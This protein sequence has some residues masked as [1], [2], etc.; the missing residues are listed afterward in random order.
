MG[1]DEDFG[2]TLAQKVQFMHK[3][4]PHS[5]VTMT[6]GNSTE[7][8]TKNLLHRTLAGCALE[9]DTMDV[10]RAYGIHRDWVTHLN[11]TLRRQFGVS[12]GV[13][14]NKQMP[15]CYLLG[16]AYHY[17]GVLS[18]TKQKTYS[19]KNLVDFHIIA[20]GFGRCKTA[21]A[22]ESRIDRA[23]LLQVFDT[24]IYDI[25]ETGH[26]IARRLNIVDAARGE[27]FIS[28][29]TLKAAVVRGRNI[30]NRRYRAVAKVDPAELKQISESYGDEDVATLLSDVSRKGVHIGADPVLVQRLRKL[31]PQDE[32]GRYRKDETDRIV[33]EVLRLD[34]THRF[35][36]LH[37]LTSRL[38]QKRGRGAFT[39]PVRLVMAP[40]MDRGDIVNY[41]EKH[42]GQARQPILF[43]KRK[44]YDQFMAIFENPLD[45]DQG[46]ENYYTG[47]QVVG[48]FHD[49]VDEGIHPNNI[50]GWFD[51][52]K[53][54]IGLFEKKPV[55]D[56]IRKLAGNYD[57]FP[58]MTD[59][60]E[61]AK[62][63]DKVWEEYVNDCV[64]S[65]LL[66]R[67]N[68]TNPRYFL[69]KRGEAE[70]RQ[71]R[72]ERARL[73]ETEQRN[74]EHVAK[75]R[76]TLVSAEQ[77]A[78]LV[79]MPVGEFRAAADK[80]GIKYRKR[81]EAR[82]YPAQSLV[83]HWPDKFTRTQSP[84]LIVTNQGIR[85]G[86]DTFM[87]AYE[88]IRD[89]EGK[90][91]GWEGLPAIILGADLSHA[92]Q[93]CYGF[94]D[95]EVDSAL[96]NGWIQP[97]IGLDKK[98][99]Y[100]RSIPP[101][102]SV[103]QSGYRVADV[104][105]RLL[106]VMS[107]IPKH[108]IPQKVLLG[109]HLAR[110]T[111]ELRR[112][113]IEKYDADDIYNPGNIMFD[114]ERHSFR[115]MWPYMETRL[116]RKLGLRMSNIGAPAFPF[117]AD[118]YWR[119][120]VPVIDIA[121]LDVLRNELFEIAGAI[122]AQFGEKKEAAPVE[123]VPSPRSVRRAQRRIDL[124]EKES[125][126]VWWEEFIDRDDS[127]PLPSIGIGY[128][129]HIG[130]VADLGPGE[131]PKYPRA[132]AIG[133]PRAEGKSRSYDTR[134]GVILTMYKDMTTN[135]G[136]ADV[137]S[138]DGWHR[139]ILLDQEH[140]EVPT[141]DVSLDELS[142]FV[143]GC[144][145]Q[146][147]EYSVFV[148]SGTNGSVK[149]RDVEFLVDE[150]KNYKPRLFPN[151][152]KPILRQH[153]DFLKPRMPE[154]WRKTLQSERDARSDEIEAMGKEAEIKGAAQALNEEQGASAEEI[155]DIAEGKEW[156]S[157]TKQ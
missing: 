82:L 137:L 16:A 8:H 72:D 106:P 5:A 128:Y 13:N 91:V 85:I 87:Q 9:Y 76:A 58:R 141:G 66:V 111:R 149:R 148:G 143:P 81:G 33:D 54:A 145:T 109:P 98:G 105:E 124:F 151:S 154:G 4:I 155:E 99:R 156:L 67:L 121:Q 100:D 20:P 157:V 95:T 43:I 39:D 41:A 93:K 69:R 37:S 64:E 90:K 132:L 125:D 65:G 97:V 118:Y 45:A 115:N 31:I 108:D 131:G 17:H 40:W 10:F 1:R 32:D 120:A 34:E 138:V 18:G 36:N 55:D 3:A 12:Q 86:R 48:M 84:D 68:P 29:H 110:W 35:I 127:L 50:L 104:A 15:L 57:W 134:P 11:H 71:G 126:P 56:L 42:G 59:V 70:F 21:A 6:K 117:S 62:I 130:D 2:L 147:P 60:R 114:P 142:L 80:E 140:M 119:N 144:L 112:E 88:F 44:K 77:A 150:W 75:M 30:V 52:P 7:V 116:A 129:W 61:G 146:S 14:M 113:M 92:L 102:W 79:G 94:T 49:R 122:P 53:N 28:P 74:E 133:D 101:G 27:E 26:N 47:L 136:M 96:G 73:W 51:L 23:T 152:L 24:I 103:A 63:P 107:G 89:T 153:F 83:E 38:R 46:A 123:K 22:G 25:I 19:K 78:Q 139:F 135:N